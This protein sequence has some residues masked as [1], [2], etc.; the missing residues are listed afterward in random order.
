MLA[1]KR[2]ADRNLVI[3]DGGMADNPRPALYGACHHVVPVVRETGPA[4]LTSV[5]GRAC[6]SDFIADASLPDGVARGDL[7]AACTT[8]AYTYS[9]SSN[10]KAFP[11]PAVV[12]VED[13]A[14]AL[15]VAAK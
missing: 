7:L 1:V 13:G 5:F 6:E 3:V 11:L 15:W 8:G 9:M 2:R 14:P 12:A 10:Y 4:R